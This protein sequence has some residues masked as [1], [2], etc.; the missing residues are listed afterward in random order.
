M[1]SDTFNV[2]SFNGLELNE[3][4]FPRFVDALK[5]WERAGIATYVFPAVVCL[6]GNSIDVSVNLFYNETK[7][8]P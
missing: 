4:R 6:V 8:K 3:T 2:E 5:N 7:L 1:I